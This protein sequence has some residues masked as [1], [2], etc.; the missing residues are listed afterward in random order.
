MNTAIRQ[1]RIGLFA[2]LLTFPLSG[3]APEINAQEAH[4]KSSTEAETYPQETPPLESVTT[5]L[6]KLLRDFDAVW[7]DPESDNKAKRKAR[8]ST[9]KS[10]LKLAN[11]T[12]DSATSVTILQWVIKYNK[13][14][15]KG[16]RAAALLAEK[17]FAEPGIGDSIDDDTDLPLLSKVIVDNPDT[18]VQAIARFFQTKNYETDP[19]IQE[20]T[21]L[22]LQESHAQTV[23]RG[24]TLDDMI[25]PLLSAMQF[26]VGKI[27]PEI[28]GPDIDETEFKLSDYR[29]KIVVLDFWGDW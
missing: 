5:R 27:A 7:D 1:T 2:I 10:L 15:R 9:T 19:A 25:T 3:T 18:Q 6:A 21:L 12:S 14:N 26:Q 24:K 22:D 29:G 20:Q 4:Q 28:V 11:E 13:N 17:H 23:Y 8:S 16:R